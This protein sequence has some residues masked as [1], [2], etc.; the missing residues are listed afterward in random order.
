M[1]R[2]QRIHI[3]GA[4]Y[5]VMLRGNGGQ[6]IFAD[7]V[8]RR[9]LE[10]LLADGVARFGHRVHAYCWMSNHLHLCLQVG[11]VPLSRIMQNLAF[12]YTRAW[13]R[14]QCRV[15]HLFQGRYRALLAAD[16][17][18]LLTLVRYIHRNPLEARL[19]ADAA[20]WPWSSHGAYVGRRRTP[21]WLT[22]HDVLARL[23]PD[24]ALAARRMAAWIVDAP[25]DPVAQASITAHGEAL[26]T[27]AIAVGPLHGARRADATLPWQIGVPSAQPFR[28]LPRD[29]RRQAL[30]LAPAPSPDAIVA[31]AARAALA[32][33]ADVVSPSRTARAVLARG[34]AAILAAELGAAT[35]ADM[36]RHLGR[37]AAALG[38]AAAKA[39]TAL[40]TAPALAARLAAERGSLIAGDA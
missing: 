36:A 22:T 32:R 19:I 40:A 1:A 39:R 7:D 24:P 12:R 14:R 15:G 2:R 8:D 34:L 23:A 21:D 25:A 13:N 10:R 26:A 11:T 29:H 5:H 38:R 31:A 4:Y 9:G 30:E 35:L 28:P 6:A 17:S 37:D 33:H 20:A 27:G 3:D 16:D 18:Y